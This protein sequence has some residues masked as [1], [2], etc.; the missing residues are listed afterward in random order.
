MKHAIIALGL[1]TAVLSFAGKAA[2]IVSKPQDYTPQRTGAAN[3]SI[4]GTTDRQVG[5]VTCGKSFGYA[6]SLG[7]KDYSAEGKPIIPYKT[8]PGYR[9]GGT[10]SADYEV[11]AISFDSYNSIATVYFTY[12]ERRQ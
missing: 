5:V 8:L 1:A 7:C 2:V 11:T 3:A 12:T 6:Y 4:V 9:L 10:I